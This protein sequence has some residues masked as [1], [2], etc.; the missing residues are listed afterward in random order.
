M[1]GYTFCCTLYAQ[2]VKHVKLFFGVNAG[3]MANYYSCHLRRLQQRVPN[4]RNAVNYTRYAN[5]FIAKHFDKLRPGRHV[6]RFKK[7]R[8]IHSNGSGLSQTAKVPTLAVSLNRK[9]DRKEFV[10]YLQ[11]ETLFRKE[12]ARQRKA[13]DSAEFG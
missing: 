2:A 6:Y 12:S 1:V 5:L 4:T 7:T 8:P 11:R 9:R 13:L 10:K 3:Q